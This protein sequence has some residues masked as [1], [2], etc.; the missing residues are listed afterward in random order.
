MREPDIDEVTRRL[1][2]VVGRKRHKAME[3]TLLTALCTPAFVVAGALFVGCVAAYVFYESPRRFDLDATAFY[4]AVNGFLAYMVV[5]TMRGPGM[6]VEDFRFDRMWVIGALLFVV[7]LLLTYATSLPQQPA[8]FGIVYAVLGFLVLGFV[9][10]ALPPDYTIRN[11]DP[12][13]DTVAITL[14][15]PNLIALAYRELLSASWLWL[16]PKPHEVRIAARLL[17]ALAADRD[18]ALRQ[19][20]VEERIAIL[21]SRLKLIRTQD[22]QLHLTPEGLDFLHATVKE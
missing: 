5:M 21:L 20:A 8:L 1:E 12:T 13:S 11:D 19:E 3:V 6:S 7:L 2:A 17:C 14:A 9:S 4:T 10:Q 22:R 15:I 16:P 18:N